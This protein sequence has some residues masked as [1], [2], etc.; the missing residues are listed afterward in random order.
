MGCVANS[1]RISDFL[2]H[3]GAQQHCLLLDPGCRLQTPHSRSFVACFQPSASKSLEWQHPLHWGPEFMSVRCLLPWL[4][5]HSQAWPAAAGKVQ[6]NKEAA[7]TRIYRNLV[8]HVPQDDAVE[9][10][11]TV[12]QNMLLAAHLSLP[13]HFTPHRRDTLVQEV[14]ELL[15]L[16]PLQHCLV[17]TPGAAGQHAEDTLRR[18]DAK[19]RK[20]K[21]CIKISRTSFANLVL[22]KGCKG[23]T[24]G[25]TW[26]CQHQSV[27]FAVSA[28]VRQTGQSTQTFNLSTLDNV[29]SCVQSAS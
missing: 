14:L 20:G 16:T 27:S 22:L 29:L 13:P 1:W 23:Y 3:C 15:A 4:A 26:G 5:S 11:L 9:A 12:A 10:G 21:H 8:R 17:G 18:Y 24:E 7:S 6:Y 28:H 19:E 2:L 25:P